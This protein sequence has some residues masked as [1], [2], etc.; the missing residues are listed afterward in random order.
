MAM[1][2]AYH[3]CPT[4]DYGQLDLERAYDNVNWSFASMLIHRMG[5]GPHMSRIIFLLGQDAVSR[6]ML[7][8]W[9][10]LDIVLT[11]SI[12]QGCPLIP[13]LF[14]IVTHPL[15]V[16]LARFATN[17]DIVGLHL[18]FEGQ[19]IANALV[20]D[21]FMFLRRGCL[22][23]TN[24]HWHPDHIFIGGSLV[25]YHVLKDISNVKDGKDPWLEK[26]LF[27]N[28]WGIHWERMLRMTNWLYGCLVI[29]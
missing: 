16:M 23:G 19:L 2:Y 8:G 15:L 25:S 11:R 7:N 29:N 26:V 1:D 3:T 18:P 24:L 27:S 6:V 9:I 17:G 28:I 5:F 21:A 14:A 4:I 20:D 13:L 10:I 22:Y 12:H